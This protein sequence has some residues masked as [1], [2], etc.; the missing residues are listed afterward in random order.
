MSFT[1]GLQQ[2]FPFAPGVPSVPTTFVNSVTA[3]LPIVSS[4]G[5]NPNISLQTPLA[6]IYGGTGTVTPS[7]VN[8]TNTTVSGT[9]PA[10]AVNV[11]VG[12]GGVVTVTG[13]GNIVS[14]GGTSPN[15]TTVASPTF[16]NVT[17]TGIAAANSLAVTA[18]ATAASL[19]LTTPLPI[20]SG[21]TATGA[22][23]LVNGTNTTVS[24]TWPA[25][26]VNVVTGAGGVSAVTASGN[27]AS[28]GGT[29]PNITIVAN[30]SFS[31]VTATG[32]ISAA[33][34]ASTSAST[35]AGLTVGTTLGVTGAATIGSNLTAVGEIL[36][37]PGGISPGWLNALDYGTHVDAHLTSNILI[38]SVS[39]SV[40][41]PVNT[42]KFTNAMHVSIWDYQF[43]FSGTVTAGGG[44][45]SL[46]VQCT[47]IFKGVAGNTMD[48]SIPSQAE[49]ISTDDYA[50]IT[51]A[52]A[53]AVPKGIVYVP[54]GAYATGTTI[55]MQ[56][57]VSLIFAEPCSIHPAGTVAD[58]FGLTPS[59]GGGSQFSNGKYELPSIGYFTQG[60]GILIVDNGCAYYMLK[61][62]TIFTCGQGIMVHTSTSNVTPTFIVR[63]QF[64]L[65]NACTVGIKFYST[66]SSLDSIQGMHIIGE[67]IIACNTAMLFDTNIPGIVTTTGG[68]L[69]VPA[70]GSPVTTG[71]IGGF[72]VGSY[73][74]AYNVASNIFWYFQVTSA[75]Q[76]TTIRGTQG[77]G[78]TLPAGSAI[79]PWMIL[80]GNHIFEVA[81]VNGNAS[82]FGGICFSRGLWS[83]MEF[84]CKSS[85]GSLANSAYLYTANGG[86]AFGNYYEFACNPGSGIFEANYNGFNALASPVP[87]TVPQNVLRLVSGVGAVAISGENSAIGTQTYNAVTTTNT[88]ASFNGGQAVYNQRFQVLMQFPA[89]L[90]AGQVQ[91]FYVYSPFAGNGL[92]T[93]VVFTPVIDASP[94]PVLLSV[95]DQHATHPNEIRIRMGCV[96]TIALNSFAAG[97]ISIGM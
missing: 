88:R 72:P 46:T 27:A 86:L 41:V 36:A 89:G 35:S 54:P 94:F 79:L 1:G 74:V 97:T 3:T 47:F 85:F 4:G 10:Q 20:A 23:S 67:A 25:Q 70:V 7:L 11:V 52:I 15:I 69:T 34:V 96:T 49:G 92:S 6:V 26:A 37:G 65:I 75:T 30:P 33:T 38:P 73:G 82:G 42:T 76:I 8:G 66:G 21:G 80:F 44:T 84:V 57:N 19:A 2:F 61:V 48:S 55:L 81:C 5:I 91:D 62:N 58:C 18:G 78:G 16:T 68:A 9:W 60:A 39:S 17:A 87:S 64:Q 24:G 45:N 14:S 12:A 50:M 51:A 31:S 29:A 43:C 59:T 71:A 93:T 53:A 28:S 22:P 95:N 90:T 13:S 32:G 83:Q 77:V 63:I 56:Q 40:T